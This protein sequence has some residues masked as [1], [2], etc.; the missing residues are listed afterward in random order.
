ML[1]KKRLLTR[2]QAGAIVLS[3]VLITSIAFFLWSSTKLNDHARWMENF[4]DAQIFRSHLDSASLQL[5]SPGFQQ[6]R[7]AQAWLTSE[8]EYAQWSLVRVQNRYLLNQDYSHASLISHM[9]LSFG[10]W[11]MCGPNVPGW[12]CIYA[13]N[14]TA[15]SSLASLLQNI[16]GKMMAAYGNFLNYTSADSVR[17]P[18]I[19]YAGPEP[20]DEGLLQQVVALTATLTRY[21]A[22]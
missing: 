12:T 19:W 5:G 7:T 14:Q 21:W 10:D 13:L 11:F 20:P 18:S 3:V 16:G 17:G 15:R 9:Y 1:G 2:R 4:R 6:D 8:I 22:S